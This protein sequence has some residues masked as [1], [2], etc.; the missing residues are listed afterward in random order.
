[1]VIL[2]RRGPAQASFTNAEIKDLGKLETVDIVVDPQDIELDANSRSLVEENRAAAVNLEYLR[3]YAEST[4]HSA[5]RRIIMRFLASPVE[6][7]SENGQITAVKIERNKLVVAPNG[8]LVAQGTGEFEYIAAGLVLR[9][10]GYRSVPI[11]GVPFD[12]V[13]S[14]LSNIAGRIVHVDTRETVSGE[15]VVGWAKRGPSG[16]IG[17]NKSDAAATVDAMLTDLPTLQGISD[18]CRDQAQ[19]TT[20]L[21]GRGIDYVT[22]QD[23]Q[24]LDRYEVERGAEL[25]CPRV[26]VTTTSEMMTIIHQARE[27]SVGMKL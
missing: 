10:I 12:P 21:H 2:G 6:I 25:G 15:Y 20:F 17:N 14:T 24:Q 27:N 13:T 7:L 18:M 9:S 8:K 4:A 26:K 3:A 5:P 11:E 16:L 1:V 23:W 19:I 22:Y